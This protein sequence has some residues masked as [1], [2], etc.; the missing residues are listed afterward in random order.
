MVNALQPFDQTVTKNV[1]LSNLTVKGDLTLRKQKAW[2]ILIYCVR[3]AFFMRT[4]FDPASASDITKRDVENTNPVYEIKADLIMEA[5]GY[6]KGN[7]FYNYKIILDV[8]ISLTKEIIG[9]DALGFATRAGDTF[10]MQSYATLIGQ[11]DHEG[12]NFRIWIPPLTVYFIVNPS[13]SFQSPVNWNV[14]TNKFSPLIYDICL[15]FYQ[16]HPAMDLAGTRVTDYISIE[17]LRRVT[18]T[19]SSTYNDYN[20][21]KKRVI[22]KAL[23]NI[24]D[25]KSNLPLTIQLDEKK[26]SSSGIGRKKVSHIRFII[27]ENLNHCIQK[28]PEQRKLTKRFVIDNLEP[29]GV[30]IQTV[31]SVMKS[32]AD[33]AD[34]NMEYLKWCIKK[35]QALRGLS[36]FKPQDSLENGAKPINFGGYFHKDIVRARKQDWLT[37]QK[38]FYAFA[39]KNNIVDIEGNGSHVY[40]IRKACMIKSAVD[41]INE[42]DEFMLEHLRKKFIHF[43]ATQLPALID[44]FGQY[45]LLSQLAEQGN[46]TLL[47][48]LEEEQHRF[49]PEDYA[50]A[51]VALNPYQL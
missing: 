51:L 12:G 6:K 22:E 33:P 14:F 49:T 13:V 23:A 30:P 9:A 20:K 15:Y 24:N 3:E 44:S 34:P 4:N 46:S 37:S 7:G 25:E 38:L 47:L 31:E 16:H 18:G 1:A 28:S 42:Q 45:P 17:D 39:A 26:A 21:L 10:D 19:T 11:C 27:T 32:A 50:Q 48:F 36:R 29:L 40:K 43:V 5:M 35:G 41:Y 2:H 8:F